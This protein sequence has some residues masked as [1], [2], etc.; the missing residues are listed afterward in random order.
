MV[1][2]VSRFIVTTVEAAVRA[3]LL[4]VGVTRLLHYQVADAIKAGGLK[5]L[6]EPFE[7]APAPVSLVHAG[8][9]QMPLKMRRFID[10][11]V[12]RLRH[13]LAEFAGNFG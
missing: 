7:P 13:S 12:P 11:A 4:H 2:V 3:A 5:I 9:G 6:L 10:F 1:P 8:R